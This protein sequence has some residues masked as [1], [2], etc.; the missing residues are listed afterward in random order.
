MIP[1]QLS[2][3]KRNSS[4]GTAW[5][6]LRLVALAWHKA[7]GNTIF[8]GLQGYRCMVSPQHC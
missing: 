8:T 3:Q 7:C 2:Q 5:Q 4:P 6:V 1:L